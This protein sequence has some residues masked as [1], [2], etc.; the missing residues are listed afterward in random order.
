MRSTILS[1]YSCVTASCPHV[2]M[3]SGNTHANSLGA[4]ARAEVIS[5]HKQVLEH[6]ALEVSKVGLPGGR[7]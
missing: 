5:R 2:C 7:H 6:H 3:A 4:D 1:V